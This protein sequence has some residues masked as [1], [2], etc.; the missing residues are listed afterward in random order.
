ML[1]Q[2]LD[3]VDEGI[4]SHL[5]AELD[6]DW[7]VFI[8]HFLGVD[9]IGHTHSAC[10]PKMAERLKVWMNHHD[11]IIIVTMIIIIMQMMDDAVIKV[12]DK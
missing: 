1:M 7:D 6:G 3:T 4:M 2:D 5:W 12:I 8:V 11:I 9:H 10:H